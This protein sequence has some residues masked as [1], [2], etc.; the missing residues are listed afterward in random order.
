MLLRLLSLLS[1]RAVL[2]SGALHVGLAAGMA[3]GGPPHATSGEAEEAAVQM[4]EVDTVTDDVE[5]SASV[6]ERRSDSDEAKVATARAPRAAPHVHPY[7]VPRHEARAHDPSARHPAAEPPSAASLAATPSFTLPSG[8]SM[9]AG[10]TRVAPASASAAGAGDGSASASLHDAHAVDVPAKVIAT[11]TAAYP[12]HAREAGLEVDVML[13][14]V[15]DHS[16]RVVHAQAVR[17][18]DREIDDAALAAV[19][20]YRFSPAQRQGRPVRV[21]MTWAVQFRL[22]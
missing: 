7:V 5:T 11:V 12:E 20:Q 17:S 8:G 6:P 3:S 15:V 4:L 2:A 9:T 16:G 18:G 21:R 19:R 1:S 13:D 14:I 22:R 10:T